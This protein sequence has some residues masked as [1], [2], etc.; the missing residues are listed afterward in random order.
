MVNGGRRA[1]ASNGESSAGSE[2]SPSRAARGAEEDGP[3]QSDVCA[4]GVPDLSTGGRRPAPRHRPLVPVL[5][6][7]ALGIALD[8][9]LAPA[10]WAWAALGLV[11]AASAVW[12]GRRGLGGWGRWAV[13]L[14]LLVPFG[15][16][17]HAVRFREKPSWHLKNLP[18][19]GRE[20]Y[21]VRGRVTRGPRVGRRPQAFLAEV[22]PGNPYWSVALEVEGISSDGQ[23]W[24]RAAGG[25]TVFGNGG[26]PA[27]EAGDEVE[28]LA[29]PRRGRA[30]TN[31]GERDTSLAAERA[32][33]YATASVE[34]PDGLTVVEPAPWHRS[35]PVAVSRLRSAVWERLEGQMVRAGARE[36]LGLVAALLL[37]DRSALSAS[38][39]RLLKES[40]TLHF[41]AISG[42]HVGLFALLMGSVLALLPVPVRLRAVTLIALMWFYVLFTGFSVSAARAGWM[43]TLVLAAPLLGRQHDL[44]SGMAGTALLILVAWPQQLFAAGFQLTFVAVWAIVCIYPQVAGTLWPWEDLVAR[45]QQPEERSPLD[46]LW[47]CAKSYALLSFVVCVATAPLLAYHFNT[48][49]PWSPLLNLFMWP[50]I[51][52]FLGACL[53]LTICLPFGYWVARPAVWLAAFLAGQVETLVRLSDGL[54]A[55]GVYM[56]R[57]ALWWVALFYAVLGV[58]AV[59]RPL[60]L[61]RKAFMAAAALLAFT[62]VAS[63]VAARAKRGL[64]LT[65]AD[66]GAGQAA[67]L[68]APE[69]QAFLFDAGSA[70]QGAEEAVADLLWHRRVSPI[71][72]LVLSH[73][74]RDHCNFV[75]YLSDRFTVDQTVVPAAGRLSPLAMMAR[76]WLQE[77]GLTVRPVS[78]EAQLTGGPIRCL[79]LHPD[80]RFA[81]DL[82]LAE[83]EKC[84]VLH[85]TCDGLTLLLPGDI[86]TSAIQRLNHVYGDRL[87]AD[88]LLMPHHGRYS[89]G[90]E[91]FVEHVRPCVAV[92][93]GPEAE[94]DARTRTILDERRVP[95]W[96]TETEGAVVITLRGALAH[97][98]GWR[99]GR[100][101]EFEPG[102]PPQW[103]YPGAGR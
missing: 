71:R 28:F 2:P 1:P 67:L 39:E 46:D 34:S 11:V 85:V 29:R 17:W 16:F 78:E 91:E 26:E 6:G 68:Q 47:V 31:P 19:D 30:P 102:G 48:V 63:E 92:V 87:K 81:C 95:L 58:W 54:P 25:M 103:G 83:N 51:L 77:E 74:D 36:R 57:P 73:F 24:R 35:V 82:Q 41:L 9:A 84:L 42:L 97:V 96:I 7:L 45:V 13:A 80:M 5:A 64:T 90:L 4:S 18:L 62:L 70:R 60:R 56:P 21:Y 66:V 59:R 44:L 94:C 61:G 40:G 23:D 20:L 32:G 3:Q 53:V 76:R 10:S 55:S 86:Q 22:I 50:L 101:L 99:S 88:V 72:V 14:V 33:S 69:G 75:P 98:V 79:V 27:A 12:G 89:E 8:T 37:G 38:Q 65:V 43:L 49:N 52:L 100:S 15:G 93:S